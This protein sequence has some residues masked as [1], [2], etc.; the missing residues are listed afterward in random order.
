MI[1][2]HCS[3]VVKF[4]WKITAPYEQKDTDDKKVT[5]IEIF[6]DE[7][8][9]CERFVVG[10]QKGFLDFEAGHG[11]EIKADPIWEK[12][13]YPKQNSF[14]N[15]AEIP[16][17]YLNDYEESIKI[18]SASPKA[19][20]A[21]SRRL[22]QNIIR[23]E[24]DIKDKSLAKE[25]DLFINMDGIP[26]HIY[27][28][29]DAVRIIGNIAAHPSKDLHTGEI[30]EVESGEAEWLIEVIE[31]LFDFTFIQPKKLERRK[32][33]LNLKLEKLGKTKMK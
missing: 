10:I 8:P 19:S 18:I 11:Y 21:L 16:V 2:P 13:I 17:K 32:D 33:E 14:Q 3:T 6:Y 31:A 7:C 28:A 12:I 25:I 30:V 1:C 29:V 24:F 15:S 5:G 9:N 22:L 20:A 27:E 26:S 23:E 4:D